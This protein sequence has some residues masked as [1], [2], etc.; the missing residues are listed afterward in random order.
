VAKRL[1]RV[2]VQRVMVEPETPVHPVLERVAA[3]RAIVLYKLIRAGLALLASA[4]LAVLALS[5]RAQSLR[6]VATQLREHA[7]SGVSSELA[8]L[9]V[10]AVAPRHFWIAVVGLAL[11]GSVTLLEGWALRRGYNWGAWLVVVM[12][13]ALLPFE[14]VAFVHRPHVG[15]AL[16]LLGNLLVA[17]YLAW[18]V[19]RERREQHA[20][21]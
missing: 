14:L 13:A 16:L 10:N 12:T 8:A 1:V 20:H 18:R 15:R 3:V 5:G 4:T 2:Q 19:V 11:D 17:V 7:T 6:D 9:L 21:S